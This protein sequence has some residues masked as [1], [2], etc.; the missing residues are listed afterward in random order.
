METI[1]HR[2][3]SR[4]IRASA[5]RSAPLT[6]LALSSAADQS[7]ASGELVALA[8]VAHQVLGTPAGRAGVQFSKCGMP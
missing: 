6:R 1:T 4:A 2:R 5:A 7:H 3:L 8:V